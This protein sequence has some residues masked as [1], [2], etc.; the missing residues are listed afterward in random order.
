[1]GR[2]SLSAFECLVDRNG[3]ADAVVD[4]AFVAEGVQPHALV[5]NPND[6][7]TTPRWKPTPDLRL[8]DINVLGIRSS[9]LGAR[10]RLRFSACSD[11][12]AN[13]YRRP[14]WPEPPSPP[15]ATSLLQPH[16]GAGFGGAAAA[17]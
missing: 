1:M 3:Q 9:R 17:R 8:T 2:A 6:A 12:P 11:A 16:Q 15:P 5:L 13:R 7:W 10:A 14:L 4:P